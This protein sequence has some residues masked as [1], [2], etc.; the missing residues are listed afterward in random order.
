MNK[1]KTSL[2]LRLSKEDEKD[3][4]SESIINQKQML[5][6]FVSNNN[7]L[8]LVSIKIDDGYSGA[9]FERPAFKE[10]LQDIKDKKVNCIVVKD[11]S[12][13]GRDF[14]EVGRYLDEIFPFL[15]VRFISINDNYDSFNKKDI[16]NNFIVPFKNLL[17]DSY[18]R[19]I[20]LKI[21]SSLD[22][23][24]KKGEFVGSFAVYGYLKDPNNKNKLIIDDV[25]SKVV[26][27]IFKYFLQGFSA[28]GIAKILNENGILCP[29]EYKRHLGMNFCTNFK[30]KEK[31]SWT[32]Q[33]IFRILK[34]PVYI[35]VLEQKKRTTPNYKINNSISV[36][37]EEQIIINDNHSPIIEKHIF[38]TVQR[39]LL[40]DTRV[41]PNNKQVYPLSGILYC[42]DCGEPLIRKNNGKKGKSNMVY[43]CNGAKN[44]NGCKG[45]TIKSDI[46]EELVFNSIK[47][48]IDHLINIEKALKII[49]KLPYTSQQI[50]KVDE[51][52]KEKRKELKK[53]QNIKL[54]LYEDLKDGIL[55]EDEYKTFNI[56]Y[57]KKIEEIQILINK[58][59]N[60][61]EN[62]S[63]G[64]TFNQEFIKYFKQ[65]KNI[66]ELKRELVVSLI[67]NIKVYNTKKIDIC[68]NYEDEYKS[69]L[70][71][72]ENINKLKVACN[73]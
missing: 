73:G 1:F 44:K 13:F 10:L 37:K 11:F 40:L 58:Y 27:D 29:V 57:T 45:I 48:Q 64:N 5:L 42:G 38:N 54:K 36:P 18:L 16:N 69:L 8:E 2:Y 25:A 50:K 32:A 23:K 7:D 30:I 65:N 20:S 46:I 19:D 14:I 60:E 51:R 52:I 21:R 59:E 71:Y 61:I 22:T 9:N 39:V 62:L 33:A 70:S 49:N 63:K 17:N 12:R 67:Y 56:S 6:D 34:N 72:I 35:G 68:F 15:D 55:T 28:Y 47:N 66:S 26:Q 3:R 4:E 31:S 43:I 53:Y 24:R 41:S